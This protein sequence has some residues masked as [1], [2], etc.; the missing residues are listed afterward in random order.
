MPTKIQK[1]FFM[2]GKLRK[3]LFRSRQ[4]YEISPD[5]KSSELKSYYFMMTEQ[6]MLSGHSQRYHFDKDGIPII[7]SYID[8]QDQKMVYY[9]ISIGQYGLAIWQT[10]LDTRK[11]SDKIRF[12]KIAN[13]FSDNRIDDNKLGSYWLTNVDKPAYHMEAPW[14]SAFSQARAINILLRA[15]QLTRNSEYH[16]IAERALKPFQ[17]S[18][19]EGGVTSF[20]NEG[21][22]YEEYPSPHTAVLVLNGMIFSMFGIY[23]YMRVFPDHTLA[24]QLFRQG[25]ATLLNILPRY[26]MGFWSKYS[27]CDADF[28]PAIDPSTIGYHHL[29][30]LQLEVMF[31][32]T[33]ETLFQE[34]TR[35]WKKDA[36]WRN[37]IKM[38]KIKF[39]AL[40]TMNRL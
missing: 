24:A 29:H 4:I 28:H 33:G 14:K 10:S 12:L 22:F 5:L 16:E 3:D 37:I 6:Q 38:Y 31:Q 8:V 15:F 18:I 7:P 13:W 25:T 32:L 23:D 11:E 17:Y 26:D 27:L 20:L 30:I 21:W 1:T 34:Y 19:K 39:K 2:L 40:K 36:N 9:P 35:K